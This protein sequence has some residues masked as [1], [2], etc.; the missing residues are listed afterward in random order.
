MG[1]REELEKAGWE[2]RGT[3]DEPRLSEIV[4]MYEETGFEVR[5]EDFDPDC[6]EG[7]VACM[8]LEPRRYKTIYIR[9][10]S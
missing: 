5:Q 3:F 6:E 2:N 8:R 10:P 7:C 9:K 1:V 4:E